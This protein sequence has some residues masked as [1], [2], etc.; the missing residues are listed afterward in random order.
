M[1]RQL[2][3]S[4]TVVIFQ[5][6]IIVNS[7]KFFFTQKP[8]KIIRSSLYKI[9]KQKKNEKRESEAARVKIEISWIF[10]VIK[11]LSSS[12]I[13]RIILTLIHLNVVVV[14]WIYSFSFILSIKKLCDI[15]LMELETYVKSM[16]NIKE[17]KWKL[18]NLIFVIQNKISNLRDICKPLVE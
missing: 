16:K 4:L 13:F 10:N 3:K 18:F 9:Q 1:S 7:H 14:G 6:V 11:G 8:Q 15:F 12:K 2:W 17:T 5:R